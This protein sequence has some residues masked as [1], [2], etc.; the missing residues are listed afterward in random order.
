M[1]ILRAAF[2]LGFVAACGGKSSTTPLEKPGPGTDAP[3][4]TPVVDLA[5]LGSD[6]GADGT[7][8]TGLKCASYFGIAGPSGPEFKSCEVGCAAGEACP[9]GSTCVTI[10]DGPGAVCRPT[11][12]DAPVAE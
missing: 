11:P 12:A 3:P 10:A 2:A 4:T 7:C 9:D 8:P 6:C 5:Q 1:W